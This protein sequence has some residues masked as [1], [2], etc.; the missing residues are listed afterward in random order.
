M[1]GPWGKSGGCFPRKGRS[2]SICSWRVVTSLVGVLL[3]F[4]RASGLSLLS[5]L[6]QWDFIASSK[7]NPDWK[8]LREEEI[9][10]A[11]NL[12]LQF[13]IIGKSRQKG[14]ASHPQSNLEWINVGPC[15]LALA[16]EWRCS[17]WVLT[18]K[19]FSYRHA[20]RPTW[21]R[22][23]LTESLFPDWLI[24]GCGKL[25]VNYHSTINWV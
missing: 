22:D 15:L 12:R 16:R 9:Y 2:E 23:S 4:P 20:H 8:Q 11:Y 17:Q 3:P 1:E 6:W 5:A 14:K 10:M 24:V 18:V 21:S 13:I 19:T 7:E 25:A